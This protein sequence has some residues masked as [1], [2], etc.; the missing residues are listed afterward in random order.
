M[1]GFPR[2]DIH[3]LLAPDLLHQIIKGG[4]KDHLVQWVQDYLVLEYGE[5]GAA[6]HMSD[7]DRRSVS[8]KIYSTF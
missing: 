6:R 5:A 1:D 2:A 8:I 4:F 7:I 3:E